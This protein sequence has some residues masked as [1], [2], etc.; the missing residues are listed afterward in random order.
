MLA[1]VTALSATGCNSEPMPPEIIPESQ[2]FADKYELNP[3]ITN[4]LTYVKDYIGK[5]ESFLSSGIDVYT[6]FDAF[7]I[8]VDNWDCITLGLD[9]MKDIVAVIDKAN[10]KYIEE[11]TAKIVAERQAI[12]DA[13]Y[14]K[15]KTEAEK[16][17]KEYTKEKRKVRT[18]DIKFEE[19]YNYYLTYHTNNGDVYEYYEPTALIDPSKQSYLQLDVAKY[20]IPY[21]SFEFV[22]TNL[23][24]YKITQE[25]DWYL[26]GVTAAYVRDY[27]PT[28]QEIK[29]GTNK[30]APDFVDVDYKNKAAKKNI[31]LSGNIAM[32]GEGFTW[33]TLMKLCSALELSEGKSRHGFTQTS[34]NQFTYYTINIL[35]SP[36][37]TEEMAA[38]T[39]TG[40][41]LPYAQ[42]IAK[43]DP[44]SQVCIDWVINLYS[45]DE[46]WRA[47]VEH[48]Y[49][50]P[51]K[52][53][54]HDY[55]VDTNNYEQMRREIDEWIEANAM[56][57][58]V[59]YAVF[60][61]K[62]NFIGFSDNGL[63]D[64][65]YELVI[66]GVVYKALDAFAGKEND[67]FGTYMSENE[68]AE[69]ATILDA[70]EQ[71]EYY[72]KHVKD[73]DVKCYF[74]D[75]KNNLI[76]PFDHQAT[77]FKFD[78]D[79]NTY[80][81][82]KMQKD[83]GGYQN[84]KLLSEENVSKLMVQYIK[85]YELDQAQGK[86]LQEIFNSDGIP[87]MQTYINELF[88]E[89]E[90]QQKLESQ[91]HPLDNNYIQMSKITADGQKFESFENFTLAT[92]ATL[93]VTPTNQ[94]SVITSSI[95]TN[96]AKLT[97]Y[98]LDSGHKFSVTIDEKEKVINSLLLT[99]PGISIGPGIEVGG[100]I[101]A[102]NL[103][104]TL[105]NIGANE[106]EQT[107]TRLIATQEEDIV[108]IAVFEDSSK[109]KALWLMKKSFAQ[110]NQINLG[111]EDPETGFVWNVTK[112]AVQPVEQ[113]S[114]ETSQQLT[115]ETTTEETAPSSETPQSQATETQTTEPQNG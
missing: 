27:A 80:Y 66:D 82:A 97:E 73:V 101:T 33:E 93:H 76:Q 57:Y 48:Q 10:A 102:E 95:L 59:K 6:I 26:N 90:E 39:E 98:A 2:I 72:K 68:V 45:M 40:M 62:D 8:Q 69:Y 54:I 3:E 21:V 86:R 55:Q 41:T 88:K 24:N 71:S 113:P 12:I 19:P 9:Q 38:T 30:V 67:A 15:A 103:M 1:V 28:E 112:N 78:K 50:T 63:R 58:S 20:G 65:E 16:R 22:S 77:K 34:D 85:T 14:E 81:I 106:I 61:Q 100:K 111:T 83:D 31:I 53:N 109:I 60:D 108:L 37:S 96:P 70:V 18:D 114:Q 32:N 42:L 110:N 43:F 29:E 92:N 84:V 51:N 74:V 105:K 91:R 107:K 94:E 23:Y 25:S 87:A 52:V 44:V 13:E 35:S 104:E 5:T 4:E 56:P 79:D 115:A 36:Y 89:E 75:D 46:T 99:E 64:A 47:G 17:G 49:T 11:E 7:K